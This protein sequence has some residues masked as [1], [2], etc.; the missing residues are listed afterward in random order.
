MWHDLPVAAAQL[1]AAR[2]QMAFTLSF[3]IILASAGVAFPALMLIANYRGLRHEDPDA[4][5]LAQRWSK[6]VAVTFA[7]GA[8]TGTVLSFKFGLESSQPSPP[9]GAD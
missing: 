7:V 2:S 5:L 9:P 6:G 8:V 1:E 4:L 3:H